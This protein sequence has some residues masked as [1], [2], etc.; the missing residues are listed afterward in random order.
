MDLQEKCI[1]A[2]SRLGKLNKELDNTFKPINEAIEVLD[3]TLPNLKIN[4]LKIHEASRKSEEVKSGLDHDAVPLTATFPNESGVT[5]DKEVEESRE[6]KARNTVEESKTHHFLFADETE[7]SLRNFG[8]GLSFTPIAH[9]K[10]E[11][12]EIMPKEEM[13]EIMPK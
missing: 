2:D 6:G 11:V 10:E 4:N 3:Q 1:E 9:E 7:Q 13:S 8:F 5:Q 12:S